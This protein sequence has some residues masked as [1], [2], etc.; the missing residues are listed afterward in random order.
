MKISELIKL[1]N[2]HEGSNYCESDYQASA[3]GCA[4]KLWISILRG[5]SDFE[6]VILDITR[7]AKHSGKP[8]RPE[9][10]KD[11]DM[12]AIK[13]PVNTK[14]ATYRIKLCIESVLA[15]EY[16][17]AVREL[18]ACAYHMRVNIEDEIKLIRV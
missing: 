7:A 16:E 11:E 3:V 6:S 5:D 8:F 10:F 13:E 17:Q 2:E 4:A 9:L 15:E 18:I 12:H 1:V 14:A